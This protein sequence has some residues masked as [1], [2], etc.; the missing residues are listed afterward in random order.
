MA[1]FP[2][3]LWMVRFAAIY[4]SVFEGLTACRSRS[5]VSLYMD[6]H[7]YLGP[8]IE[9]P[10]ASASLVSALRAFRGLLRACALDQR[11]REHGSGLIRM[12]EYCMK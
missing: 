1:T 2:A 9:R 4:A 5:V 6:G 11:T 8:P 3:K 7:M 10:S 12:A